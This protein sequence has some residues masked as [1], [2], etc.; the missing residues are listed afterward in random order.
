MDVE[1][2]MENLTSTCDDQHML[3]TQL[4]EFDQDGLVSRTA[5]AEKPLRVEYTLTEAAYGLLPA[6][7]EILSWSRLYGCA[8]RGVAA[9]LIAVMLDAARSVLQQ[10]SRSH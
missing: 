8:P 10:P 7:K 1:T 3:T 4:R 6:L 2:G 9:G 5:F